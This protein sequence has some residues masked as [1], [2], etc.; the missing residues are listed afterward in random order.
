VEVGAGLVGLFFFLREIGLELIA[1]ISKLLTYWIRILG[2]VQKL[3]KNDIPSKVN[4]F[5]W[6]LL[7]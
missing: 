1:S 2:V 4:F 5:G 7:L 6:I 3:W